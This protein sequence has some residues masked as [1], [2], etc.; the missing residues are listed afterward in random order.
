MTEALQ[1]ARAAV[2]NRS[3]TSSSEVN[4]AQMTIQTQATDANGIARDAKLAFSKNPMLAAN[5][6]TGLS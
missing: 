4:I 2:G 6:N 1:N 3:S 5:A